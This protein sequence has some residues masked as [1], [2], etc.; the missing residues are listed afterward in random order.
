MLIG[1]QLMDNVRGARLARGEAAFWW[2]GQLGFIVKTASALL[3]FDPYI[4]QGEARLIPPLVSPEEL[5]GTDYILGTHDHGDHIEHGTWRAI[6]AA[7]PSTRFVLPQMLAGPLSKELGIAP[8]RMAPLDEGIVYSDVERGIT[9]SAIAS[10]H[11]FLD[12]DPA[13]GLHPSLGYIVECDGLRIY[14]SGDTLK[15]EGLESKLMALD[16]IDLFF[17]PINGRDGA[18]YRAGIIGNM[19]FREAV[20]LVGAV[21]PRLAV[22]AHYD[23]FAANSENPANFIN[24]LEAKYPEREFWVGGHGAKVLLPARGA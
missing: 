9:F 10:A 16:P 19:D 14:H 20:D 13:T 1:K 23:M 6:A 3:V 24:Y 2:L 22:P 11:E 15:Y 17:V 12:R 5:A 7:S 18:R 4:G 21:R 8:E